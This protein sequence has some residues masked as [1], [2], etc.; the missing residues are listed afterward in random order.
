MKL[1]VDCVLTHQLSSLQGSSAL[2]R[3]LSA[4]HLTY[5]DIPLEALICKQYA[6]QTT[7]DLP[8]AAISAAADGLEVG[9]AYWLRADPVYLVMQR[10]SFSLGEPV[11]LLVE[12]AHAAHIVDTLNQH[13]S[14]DGLIFLIGKSGAW[15]VKSQQ[16]QEIETTLPSVAAGKNIHQFLPQGRMAAKWRAALNEVQMLLHE[17]SVNEMRESICELAVN[18]VWFSGGGVMP[19]TFKSLSPPIQHEASL[20]VADDILHQGLSKWAGSTLQTVPNS[21]NQLLLES[22]QYAHVRIQL[23]VVT[24]VDGTWLNALL[25]ALK[26]RKI[27]QLTMNLGFYEKCL[28]AEIKPLDIYLNRYKFWQKSKPVMQ[29][30]A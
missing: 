29:Y 24:D 17:H 5:S 13:F 25:L 14:Q 12:P 18:S 6:L 7:P 3:L 16:A 20:M 4:A 9:S 11:P 1:I 23:P 26:H 27:S 21:L 19:S 15:Y 28:I 10:D 22:L 8:I 30:L 2:A